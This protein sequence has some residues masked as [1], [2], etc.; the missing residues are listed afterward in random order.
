MNIPFDLT[1]FLPSFHLCMLCSSTLLKMTKNLDQQ[2]LQQQQHRDWR[3]AVGGDGG[4][5][6]SSSGAR[7]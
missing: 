1:S 7:D 5:G 4:S 6:S 2:Q 3:T